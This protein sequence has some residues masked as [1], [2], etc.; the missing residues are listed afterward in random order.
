MFNGVLEDGIPD[1]H[2]VGRSRGEK[3][4]SVVVDLSMAGMTQGSLPA[5]SFRSNVG[6]QITGNNDEVSLLS[7]VQD[8]S[9]TVIEV[10]LG[11]I[12]AGLC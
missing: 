9:K 2:F 6:T 10:V 7:S 11:R 1:D 4:K 3:M 8:E 12:Q 5:K